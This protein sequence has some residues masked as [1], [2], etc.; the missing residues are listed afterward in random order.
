MADDKTQNIP[1]LEDVVEIGKPEEE[2]IQI[3]AD[4]TVDDAYDD[5]FNKL[6]DSPDEQQSVAIDMDAEMAEDSNDDL[7][8]DS[9]LQMVENS[10]GPVADSPATTDDELES[11]SMTATAEPVASQSDPDQAEDMWIQDWQ[12]EMVESAISDDMDSDLELTPVTATITDSTI[13]AST[14]ESFIDEMDE[15]STGTDTTEE[16]EQ[17]TV[18][19]A[20]Q[21]D[22]TDETPPAVVATAAET[23]TSGTTAKL[24]LNDADEIPQLVNEIVSGIMPEIE[25]KLRTRIRDIL[26]QRFNPED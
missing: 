15:L 21:S 12:E 16:P 23:D 2:S 6:F 4:N 20:V 25:W 1:I 18:I 26:E 13:E 8:D 19:K 24:E 22:D 9:A 7:W 3:V 5:E 11:V 14:V 17:P 10:S